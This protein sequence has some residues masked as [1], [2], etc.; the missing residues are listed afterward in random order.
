MELKGQFARNLPVAVF[1]GG[2]RFAK[3][4]K[5]LAPRASAKLASTDVRDRPK[6]P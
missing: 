6:S 3:R 5:N 2:G 1:G 4:L